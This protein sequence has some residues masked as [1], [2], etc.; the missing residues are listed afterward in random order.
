MS[1][2][3]AE[4]ADAAVTIPMAP[5]FV[6]SLNVSVAAALVLYAARA[7]RIRRSGRHADVDDDQRR[8]LEALMMLRHKVNPMLVEDEAWLRAG[9]RERGRE[10]GRHTH[11]H[12]ERERERERERGRER[13]CLH[14]HMRGRGRVSWGRG[15]LGSKRVRERGEREDIKRLFSV[16]AVRGLCVC[17]CAYLS[18]I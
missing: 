2:E 12:T 14:A 16:F 7:T 17:V 5:G 11:T 13:V 4:L 3:A 10:I 1:Q 9:E 15:P 8:I 6:E 18:V